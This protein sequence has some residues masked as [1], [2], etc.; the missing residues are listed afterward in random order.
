MTPKPWSYTA[1]E[2]FVNC[3]RAFAEK[4]VF[5]SVIEPKSEQMLWGEHVHKVFEDRQADGVVLPVDLEHHEPF[6]QKLQ[7]MPGILGV[8]QRI[9]LNTA[10]QPCEFF[11]ENVWYRGV[12]DYR[13][14]DNRRAYILDHKTG[15]QHS[16]FGQLQLFALHTFAEY[17]EVQAIKAEYYWTQ[18]ESTTGEVYTRDMMPKL[19]GK[20]IPDLKQYRQAFIE[21]TWQP[22]QSGLCNGWCPVTGC[23]FWKPRRM[24]R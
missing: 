17:P 23:E 3:P 9:A 8:E 10:G 22:R 2:D 19:W 24:K 13:K 15:K 7:D 5:K 4:R 11:G 21:D 1:L 20:F 6:M 12:I 16:K 14:I 18:T